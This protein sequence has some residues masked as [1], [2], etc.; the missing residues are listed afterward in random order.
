MPVVDGDRWQRA[1]TVAD[2]IATG[3]NAHHQEMTGRIARAVQLTPEDERFF[4]DLPPSR[5]LIVTEECGADAEGMGVTSRVVAA[6]PAADIRVLAKDEGID[7]LR[8]YL[9][10]GKYESV[11]L[12][13][14]LTPA[15]E[16]AAVLHELP[17]NLDAWVQE[18]RRAYL[19]GEKGLPPG[20]SLG[21]LAFEDQVVW[22]RRYQAYWRD[23]HPQILAEWVGELRRLLAASC[24]LSAPL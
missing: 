6:A 3:Q 17:P 19:V 10:E 5:L 24:G 15:F 20:T 11:P 12:F 7:I 4:R 8:Q 18:S 23:N 21:D 9:K 16:V 1:R 13:L 2:W 22:I 14:A